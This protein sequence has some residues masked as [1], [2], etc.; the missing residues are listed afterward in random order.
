MHNDFDMD[1]G[2]AF[3]RIVSVYSFYL[4]NRTKI[5]QVD[6]VW[7]CWVKRV[8]FSKCYIVLF[9][10][11]AFE[12]LLQIVHSTPSV[13]TYSSK[14]IHDSSVIKYIWELQSQLEN[15]WDDKNAPIRCEHNK[16]F[17]SE[18]C[19]SQFEYSWRKIF[20]NASFNQEFDQNL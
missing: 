17:S 19:I 8:S 15:K 5:D 3:F 13:Y 10:T 2:F 1:H 4:T 16:N 12:K 20:L 6:L 18:A 7:M 9:H 11:V 14:F